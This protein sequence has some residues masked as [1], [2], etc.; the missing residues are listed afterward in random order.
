MDHDKYKAAKLFTG[1]KNSEIWCATLA[2]SKDTDKSY[3]CGRS[4][5]PND[6][7]N[8]IN[9]LIDIKKYKVNILVEK[10]KS[11][12]DQDKYVLHLDSNTNDISVSDTNGTLVTQLTNEGK[13]WFGQD[14]FT[15]KIKKSLYIILFYPKQGPTNGHVYSLNDCSWF[16]WETRKEFLSNGVPCQNFPKELSKQ[17]FIKLLGI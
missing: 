1:I 11:I 3:N 2:L 7:A 8:K 17:L 4:Q 12:F 6:L 15:F 10:L 5:V 9:D 16:F 14:V 13:D